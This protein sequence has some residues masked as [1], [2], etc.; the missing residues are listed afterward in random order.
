MNVTF[1]IPK[2]AIYELDAAG[3]YSPVGDYTLG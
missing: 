1:Q 3:M 2:N